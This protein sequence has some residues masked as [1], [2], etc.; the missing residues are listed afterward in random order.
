MADLLCGHPRV[1][2]EN[3]LNRFKIRMQAEHIHEVGSMSM[4]CIAYPAGSIHQ[5]CQL[6]AD[7][8]VDMAS[9][10]AEV[11]QEHEMPGAP[12]AC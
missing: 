2:N 6:V 4:Y 1:L 5:L 9:F 3:V 10:T 11:L 12:N 8:Q 7:L